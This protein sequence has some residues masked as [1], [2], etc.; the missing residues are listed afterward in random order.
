VELERWS[1]RAGGVQHG[2][3]CAGATVEQFERAKSRLSSLKEDPGNEAKLRIYALFK[4]VRGHGALIVTGLLLP[5]KETG[6]PTAC[7]INIHLFVP[8]LVK[9][10]FYTIG[11]N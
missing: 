3:L 2:V 11:I 5:L 10:A 9:L 1:W 6:A 8:A 7:F 4:Q